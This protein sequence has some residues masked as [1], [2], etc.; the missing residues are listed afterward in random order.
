MKI[1]RR[2]KL[3]AGIIV[4][5]G[6]VAAAGIWWLQ[7]R[8][9]VT[10]PN[11]KT[12]GVPIP[13]DQEPAETTKLKLYMIAIGDNGIRG[14]KVACNDSLVEVTGT[15]PETAYLSGAYQELLELK[16]KTYPSTDL[17]NPLASSTLKLESAKLD[18]EGVAEI[19]L[20][21]GIGWSD[22]CDAKRQTEQ[23]TEPARRFY[24]VKEVRI[25]LNGKLLEQ[26]FAVPEGCY[27]EP[28]G[29]NC[30]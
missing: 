22:E 17:A 4:I 20:S 24:G 6:G 12:T 23:L 27:G 25:T 14:K 16:D 26:A 29:P 3:L 15:F 1:A 11:P 7:S 18:A 13:R 28:M 5:G 21:G 9:P 30:M 10:P 19:A 8:A 2:T